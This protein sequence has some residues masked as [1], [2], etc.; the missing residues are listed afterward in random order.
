MKYKET[1]EKLLIYPYVWFPSHLDLA[2][3]RPTEIYFAHRCFVDQLGFSIDQARTVR[4][5]LDSSL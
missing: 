1:C 2:S 3:D 5:A 4:D